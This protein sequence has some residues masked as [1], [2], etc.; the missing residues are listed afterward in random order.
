MDKSFMIRTR[1]EKDNNTFSKSFLNDI[2]RGNRIVGGKWTTD[3]DGTKVFSPYKRMLDKYGFD[4]FNRYF[5][6][7]KPDVRLDYTR[8][9]LGNANN[10]KK[11]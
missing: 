4:Q 2:K 6:E 8:Y 3:Y 9:G 7:N 11:A 1:Y 10:I 5:S